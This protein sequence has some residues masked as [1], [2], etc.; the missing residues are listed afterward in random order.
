M[1]VTIKS[2]QEELK[3]ERKRADEWRD[4]FFIKEMECHRLRTWISVKFDWFLEMATSNSRPCFKYLIKNTAEILGM[5][6]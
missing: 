4:K 3:Y 1:R 6:P 2:L 5:K